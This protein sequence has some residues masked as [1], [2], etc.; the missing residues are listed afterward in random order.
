MINGIGV[1]G[2]GVGGI[3]AEAGMLGQPVYFLTPDVVGVELK[4]Q[5]ARRRDRHR[6]GA[7]HHRDAAPRE[8]GGQ[9]RRILRRR[10]RQP[11]G[12][13]PGHHRQHGARVR[14]DHGLFPVDERTIDYF[15]GTGRTARKSA[16]LEAYFKAQKMFGVPKAKDIN[17]TKLLT[18]DLGTV[19]PSL[20]GPKR[21]QDRIEIG[22]VKNTFTELFSSPSPKTASTS[23]PTSC[24]R[25][26][27]SAGT[28]GQE[29]RHPDRRH[30]VVHQHVEPQR[31]AGRRPAGQEG[32]RGRPEGAQAHQDLAGARIARGHG[33]PDQD[34][35]AALS[36][37]SWASTAY[38]CTTCIGNAGD[39]PPT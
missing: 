8:G 19:A 11:V 15:E 29:R 1:V 10:H 27:T 14:R 2:W 13:R 24:T 30:H 6:P 9:V 28:K 22:N 36:P 31:A 38:G 35:P 17:Y 3:E 39:P 12:H 32:G 25:P 5:A 21:P 34:R 16:A 20:A 7:D 26:A 18:L 33:I 23:R 4:G 37:R